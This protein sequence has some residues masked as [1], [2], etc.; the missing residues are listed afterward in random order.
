MGTEEQVS[1]GGFDPYHKWLGI[2]P[3]DQ[4]PNHY[5]LLAID[6]FESDPDVISNAADQRMAHVRSFQTGQNADLS[7]R[8]LNEIAAA[9]VC[10]L[11]PEKKSLYD[12]SLQAPVQPPLVVVA[13]PRA[14][15]HVSRRR[16]MRDPT[17]QALISILAALVVLAVVLWMSLPSPQS[18]PPSET[19]SPAASGPK[20]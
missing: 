6:L 2:P 17:V 19:R 4:P 11:D 3:K 13:P 10:L 8:I 18:G 12:Q 1:W 20:G 5:R 15:S 14:L 16:A 7:Q 9:R